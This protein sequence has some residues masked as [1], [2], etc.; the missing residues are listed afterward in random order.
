L[1]VSIDKRACAEGW[2]FLVREFLSATMALAARRDK[3]AFRAQFAASQRMN[4]CSKR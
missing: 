3:A 4:S 2:R 1:I